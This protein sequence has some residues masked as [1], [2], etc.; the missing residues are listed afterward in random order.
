MLVNVKPSFDL[1][2]YEVKITICTSKEVVVLLKVNKTFKN[3]KRPVVTLIIVPSNK[4]YRLLTTQCIQGLFLACCCVSA[5]K[6]KQP[7]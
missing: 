4:S 3:S 1:E 6:R 5:M 7:S 2:G